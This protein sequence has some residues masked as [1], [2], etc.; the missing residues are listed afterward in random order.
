MVDRLVHAVWIDM[1]AVRA[2][3]GYLA[4]VCAPD[5]SSTFGTK[6]KALQREARVFE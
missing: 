4:F 1:D 3:I 2:G 6:T 5:S